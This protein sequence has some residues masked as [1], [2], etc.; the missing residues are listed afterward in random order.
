[1]KTFLIPIVL[2]HS[3]F[4]VVGTSARCWDWDSSIM[5]RRSSACPGRPCLL[6]AWRAVRCI[7]KLHGTPR[8]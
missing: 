3:C 6:Q 8:R 2:L 5:R 1:M 7:E 4:Y